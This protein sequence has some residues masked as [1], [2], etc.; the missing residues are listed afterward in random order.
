MFEGPDGGAQLA[1]LTKETHGEWLTVTRR[2]KPAQKNVNKQVIDDIK[3]LAE[4][5]NK[6]IA[7]TKAIGKKY[8]RDQ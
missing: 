6:D 2:K 7:T 3:N 4:K 1:K 5:S 8:G